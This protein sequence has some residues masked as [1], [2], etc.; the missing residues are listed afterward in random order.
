MNPAKVML[1]TPNFESK[2][3]FSYIRSLMDTIR[4][5]AARGIEV[6]W[7]PR[8]GD[9]LLPAC[10]NLIAMEFVKRPELTHL[11]WTDADMTWTGADVL[12]LLDHDLDIV[13]GLYRAKTP[14]VRYDYG[15]LPGVAPDPCTGLME[16]D[17]AGTG[18]MLTRRSVYEAMMAAFPERMAQ[19]GEGMYRCHGDSEPGPIFDFFPLLLSDGTYMAEDISFCRSWRTIGGRV[20]V[21]ATLRL[22][23]EGR[24]VFRGDPMTMFVPAPQAAEA[25]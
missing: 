22:G 2:F 6:V 5:L 16:V 9:S 12:R 10:R 3:H 21:D 7:W 13:A 14:E 23:H 18:F 20:M 11:L 19:R 1:A 25:A 24:H 15:A 4:A 17:C 8:C